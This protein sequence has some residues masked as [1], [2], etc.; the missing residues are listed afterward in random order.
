MI[1]KEYTTQVRDCTIHLWPLYSNFDMDCIACYFD[2]V[3]RGDEKW[4]AVMREFFIACGI[5]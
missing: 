3:Q 5:V 2:R 1:N 4:K